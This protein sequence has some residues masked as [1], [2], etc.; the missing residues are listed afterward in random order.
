[1]LIALT[2]ADGHRL[3]DYKAP[4]ST[5]GHRLPKTDQ[6]SQFKTQ[7]TREQTERESEK[8]TPRNERALNNLPKHIHLNL[9]IT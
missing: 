6:A 1:M 7:S 3:P 5:D 4:E 2:P 9:L 8:A